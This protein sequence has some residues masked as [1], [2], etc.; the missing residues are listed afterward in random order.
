MKSQI[1]S[2]P[3]IDNPSNFK[4]EARSEFQGGSKI[5][6]F[7][8]LPN[9]DSHN[10]GFHS[11]LNKIPS[12]EDLKTV[13][14]NIPYFDELPDIDLEKYVMLIKLVSNS[15]HFV[16]RESRQLGLLGGGLGGYGYVQLLY[17]CRMLYIR[18]IYMMRLL[19]LSGS[20]GL[21]GGGL[22]Y[23]LGGGLGHGLGGVW[24]SDGDVSQYQFTDRQMDLANLRAQNINEHF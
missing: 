19:Q 23:G 22:G 15:N 9:I 13:D 18:L 4:A 6:S 11:G 14:G 1:F 24:R 10:Q 21:C 2:E 5:P 7:E 12:F 3:V 16:F 20:C 17:Y 8:D